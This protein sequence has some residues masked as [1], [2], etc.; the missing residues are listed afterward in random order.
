MLI[1]AE[2]LFLNSQLKKYIETKVKEIVLVE[3]LTVFFQTRYILYY[4]LTYIQFRLLLS[5]YI[6][7]ELP[8]KRICLNNSL[9]Q[10][11]FF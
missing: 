9:Q 6:Q 4:I 1:T 2:Q 8:E 5:N 7:N 10:I 11:L 3:M